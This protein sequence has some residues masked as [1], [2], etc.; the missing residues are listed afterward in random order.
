M[1]LH[2]GSMGWGKR[3]LARGVFRIGTVLL[4]SL[5]M[6]APAVASDT[7][8]ADYVVARVAHSSAGFGLRIADGVAIA[9][10]AACTED[11]FQRDRCPQFPLEGNTLIYAFGEGD[12][13]TTVWMDSSAA[14]FAEV[15]GKITDGIPGRIVPAIGIAFPDD[16]RSGGFGHSTFTEASFFG[17]QTGPNG[18]DL[19]YFVVSRIGFEVGEATVESP[20]SNPNGD[21]IWTEVSFSGYFVF[22]GRLTRDGCKDAFWQA[23]TRADGSGF[24]NQGDCVQ[25]T[26]TDH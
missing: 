20:G 10:F 9:I 21:G 22:E 19:E 25:F 4:V 18:F 8:P 6:A 13:G 17:G 1:R 14:A 7:E 16:G 23:A 26:L 24:K 12:V 3:L 5:S 2:A 11:E 15:V